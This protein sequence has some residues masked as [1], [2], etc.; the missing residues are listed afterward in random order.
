MR[1]QLQITKKVLREEKDVCEFYYEIYNPSKEN[2]YLDKLTMYEADSLEELGICASECML[3]RSGRHKNDIP[4]VM[5]L[6]KPDGAMQDALGSM[7]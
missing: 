5:T 3:F 2:I 6:G 1:E 7:S 4:S